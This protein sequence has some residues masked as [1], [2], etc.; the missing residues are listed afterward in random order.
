MDLS[1][2]QQ[3]V[4]DD[5]KMRSLIGRSVRYAEQECEVCDVLIEEKQL[6]LASAEAETMQDDSYGRP[7]RKVPAY[8][9]LLFKDESGQPSHIWHELVFLD[10]QPAG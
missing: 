4:D 8:H 9:S 2:L 3:L 6:I 7:H 5:E 1:R 10:G